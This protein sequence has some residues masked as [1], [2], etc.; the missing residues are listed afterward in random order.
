MELCLQDNN[1]GPARGATVGHGH[2]SAKLLH[3]RISE[4]RAQLNLGG[5]MA[6][7]KDTQTVR[8]ALPREESEKQ[9]EQEADS[10]E[11]EAVL[12][13]KQGEIEG[14]N[15]IYRLHCKRVYGH[16]LR[17]LGT[18]MEA[19]DLTQEVFLQ[20]FRKIHTFRADSRLSTWLHRLTVNIVLMHF[21]RKNPPSLSLEQAGSPDFGSNAAAKGI[22]ER[23]RLSSH[24]LDGLNLE[25]AVCRLPWTWRLVFLLHDVQGYKH[26]EIARAMKCSVSSS[27]G[28]L[29]KAHLR[30][31]LLL[32]QG[33]ER[34]E[35]APEFTS[36]SC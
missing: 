34:V 26:E 8:L 17:M 28:L 12:R 9:E 27:K 14:F 33:C 5:T 20:V 6:I 24:V 21:R 32:L 35:L 16:C 2:F 19:E 3:L 15:Q 25:R 31:R 13:A 10:R 4:S 29:H 11:R 22:E 18:A 36:R 30:L 23:E 1:Y 7:E